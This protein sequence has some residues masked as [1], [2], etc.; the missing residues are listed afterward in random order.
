MKISFFI[1]NH[2]EKKHIHTNLVCVKVYII[3]LVG[4]STD[5]IEILLS[6]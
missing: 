4:G 1:V 6:I 2:M 5:S 3:T